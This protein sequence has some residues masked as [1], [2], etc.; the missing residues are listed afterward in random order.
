MK[1]SNEQLTKLALHGAA[2]NAILAEAMLSSGEAPSV[3]PETD[4]EIEV[5]FAPT[6]KDK[7]EKEKKKKPE[8]LD[9]DVLCG[10]WKGGKKKPDLMI[11]KGEPGYMAAWGKL[12]KKGETGNC[13]L[14]HEDN[15][16]LCV[17]MG[18]GFVFLYY[19]KE[20][21]TITLYPGGEYTRVPPT[22]K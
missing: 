5:L 14:I 10:D 11:F 16:R 3:Y 8:P 6:G 7:T 13:Y 9:L 1:L 12:P 19:N 17:G 4:V 15:G 18:D 21:D 20:T 2:I 22:E